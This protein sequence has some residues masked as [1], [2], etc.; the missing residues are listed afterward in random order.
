MSLSLQNNISKKITSILIAFLVACFAVAIL[1]F[2]HIL[3]QIMFTVVDISGIK[4]SMANG[5]YTPIITTVFTFT[6]LVLN[7]NNNKSPTL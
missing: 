7:Y 2:A 6:A 1:P 3:F 4:A 5:D